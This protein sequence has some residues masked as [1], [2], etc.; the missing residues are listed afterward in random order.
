M[1]NNSNKN[2]VRPMMATPK[3]F[4]ANLLAWLRRVLKGDRFDNLFE[5]LKGE[6]LRI[7]AL[8]IGEIKMLDYGCGMMEFS[9]QL[10]SQKIIS[11]YIGVDIF[12]VPTTSDVTKD[13]KWTHYKQIPKGS[14]NFNNVVF[15]LTIATDVLHHASDQDQLQILTGLSKS[16]KIILIK[17]HF[18][19]GYFSRQLLR[20]A[21][22]YGNYAYGVDIPKTYFTQSGWHDLI[23]RAGLRQISLN[24]YIKV[25]GG[26]FGLII[27]PT[28]HFISVLTAQDDRQSP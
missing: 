3:I 11:D 16:S 7:E 23:N 1:M 2:A 21:D 5:A 14:V 26:I 27:P 8:K 24:S 13:S 25:H 15:D 10:K 6:I 20:L 17:D 22:W 4:L 12:P 28:F 18:E 19:H 9:S